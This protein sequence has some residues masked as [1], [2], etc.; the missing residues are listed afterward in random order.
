M[1]EKPKMTRKE[2]WIRFGVWIFFAVI[3]PFTYIAV[4]YGI[5]EAKETT[6]S[7]WGVVA[8]IFVIAMLMYIVKQAKAG[9]PRGSMARQCID[10]YMALMPILGM[11]IL[12]NALK[13]SMDEFERFLVIMLL[14][15]AV[16]V[17]INPMP[18]WG[19]EHNVEFFEGSIAKAMATAM[20]RRGEKK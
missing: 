7:G 17:P 10:G 16:A 1:E 9:L 2:F 8:L 20:F 18:R 19:L 14:C 13:K 11:A 5:F 12:I 3:V 6:L 4:A 15:E